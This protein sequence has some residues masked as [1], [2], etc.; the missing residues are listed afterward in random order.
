[1][2][3][4][5]VGALSLHVEQ[6]GSGE[7]A[8]VFLPYWGGVARTW[9]E[10]TA[11]LRATFATVTYDPRGWG[12]SDKP[13]TGYTLSALAEEV[14][15]LIQRLD[16]SNYV[17]IGHSM[18]GKVAQL[19]ASKRPP[20]LAGLIL[21]APAPPTPVRFPEE[22]R[23][24]QI[25]AYNNRQ[26]VLYTISLLSS[27]EP[28]PHRIEQIV[29]DSLSGSRAAVLAWPTSSIL[30]DISHETSNIDVPTLVIAGELDRIDSIEQHKREVVARIRSAEFTV[31]LG[32]GHLLPIE[33]PIEVALNISRF[34]ESLGHKT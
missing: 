21:V 30:E 20:G 18:G 4:V 3:K 25:Q 7:P 5:E 12:Q 22:I 33:K 13:S 27:I 14:A 23:Q 34:V 11:E 8:L 26:N 19:V 24:S 28:A 1:M 29:E 10:V 32:S 6:S 2:A 9:N 17:L 31:I 15:Q 16:I